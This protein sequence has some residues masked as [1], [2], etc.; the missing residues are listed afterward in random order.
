MWNGLHATMHGRKHI[1]LLQSCMHG[2]LQHAC[3]HGHALAMQA[4]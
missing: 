3:R 2:E 1:M 4:R